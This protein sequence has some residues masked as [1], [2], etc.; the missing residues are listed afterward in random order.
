MDKY[1]S[2]LRIEEIEKLKKK[3]QYKEA[4]RLAD[5]IEWHRIKN[6]VTLYKVANL[7]K[8]CRNYAKCRELLE[9]AYERSP[10]AKNVVFALCDV[11][12]EFGDFEAA[13]EHYKEYAALAGDDSGI[14]ILKYKMLKALEAGI[15]EQIEILET[16][17][18]MNRSEEWEYEL[19][20]LYHRAGLG[21]KCVEEC[22]EIIT[23]YGEGSYVYKAMELKM[24]HEPLTPEQ[25]AVY[26]GRIEKRKK[27]EGTGKMPRTERRAKKT[28]KDARYKGPERRTREENPSEDDDEEEFHVKTIN[29]GQFNTIDLQAELANN[30][31]D[32]IGGEPSMI[33]R[34]GLERDD[35]DSM[36]TRVFVPKEDTTD[37]LLQIVNQAQ[38]EAANSS[39]SVQDAYDTDASLST[40]P[41]YETEAGFKAQSPYDTSAGLVEETEDVEFVQENRKEVFHNTI[42]ADSQEVFF[43]DATGD[44]R[45]QVE[46][47]EKPVSDNSKLDEFKESYTREREGKPLP[48]GLGRLSGEEYVQTETVPIAGGIVDEK[49]LDD[50]TVELIKHF[51][52]NVE[53]E[54]VRVGQ[55]KKKMKFSTSNTAGTVKKEKPLQPE[56]PVKVELQREE[57]D[58]DYVDMLPTSEEAQISGQ[59]NIQDIL[60]GWEETKR[61]KEREFQENLRKKTLENTG[62]LFADFEKEANSGL[63]ATLENPALINS[64]TDQSTSEDFFKGIS[65]EDIKKGKQI[66]YPEKKQDDLRIGKVIE[67]PEEEVLEDEALEEP[68]FITEKPAVEEATEQMSLFSNSSSSGENSTEENTSSNEE[69]VSQNTKTG[70][71]AAEESIEEATVEETSKELPE[72]KAETEVPD[73][74]NTVDGNNLVAEA[75]A[76]KKQ[77]TDPDEKMIKQILEEDEQERRNRYYGSVTQNISGNIWDEVDNVPVKETYSDAEPEPDEVGATKFMP[78][79][80]IEEEVQS[81]EATEDETVQEPE[82]S[83]PVVEK[84]ERKPKVKAKAKHKKHVEAEEEVPAED[85]GFEMVPLDQDSEA[86]APVPAGQKEETTNVEVGGDGLERELTKEEKKYFGPF[87]YSK[88]MKQQILDAIETMTLAAYTGNLIITADSG[89]SSTKLATCFYQYLKASDSNFTGKS[90]KIGAEKLNKKDMNE[91]FEKLAGGALIVSHAGKMTNSTINGIL[92]NLNQEARGVEVILHDTKNEIRRL[93]ERAPV[94]ERFFNCRVDIIAMSPEMLAEYGKKYALDLGYS[95]D[96]MAMLA[97]SGRISELQIG[98]HLVSVDEVKEIVQDAIAHADK[99]S[100]DKAIRTMTGKRYDEEH[101]V[102]LRE[103][104]FEF[105]KR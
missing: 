5:T 43:E 20:T 49:V 60:A 104:D 21:E 35:K 59:L 17:K 27:G 34:A 63:L 74:G 76:L 37:S 96:T 12:L 89:E 68:E 72:E 33:N 92:Q 47:P 83:K 65:V 55:E 15:D 82:E 102:I 77:E 4:A 39:E 71:T 86:T 22:N 32:Y 73:E 36:S 56:K 100:P 101:R 52:E 64:V 46:R 57:L 1:E 8:I 58:P 75:E 9:L 69:A 41:G 10:Y 24:L 105:R 62:N 88:R 54:V 53:P 91:I 7:Y 50:G 29:M 14:W 93:L 26:D 97:F 44:L 94:L 98:T 67:A 16:L 61:Q 13:T 28:E 84:V 11:C 103:K 99:P 87:L 25:Q 30:I 18:K 6:T 2:K 95:I 81:A 42:P 80:E 66:T 31:Q 85:N 38:Q 45:F 40:D 3:K 19:A 78:S 70:E 48:E 90:A 79:K 51:E 23:W